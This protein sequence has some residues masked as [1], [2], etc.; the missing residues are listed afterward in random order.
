MSYG[1]VALVT[2]IS[3]DVVSALSAAGYPALTDGA[4]LL[5][6]QHQFEQSAPP[7]II[8]TPVASKFGPR[9]SS[10]LSALTPAPPGGTSPGVGLLSLTM[11]NYGGN[12][13]SPT[14]SFT[15]GGG[16][17]AAATATV[18]G[19]SIAKITLTNS[20][21]GYTSAP[22]VVITDADGTG[23]TAVANLQ[24]YSELLAEAQQRSIYT[25]SVTFE[26]RCWGM[27]PTTDD[28]NGDYDYTQVLYQQMIRSCRNLAVGS[29]R[30][31]PNGNWTDGS[32]TESQLFRN[33]REFVFRIEI[34][35]PILDVLLQYA[36]TGT[37]GE[38]AITSGNDTVTVE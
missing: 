38:I 10:S 3:A 34:D 28:P 7:R 11:T 35:V 17:G 19:S 20:G 23:A 1:I 36:P 18:V 33:G 5:G 26:V 27:V 30:F 21:S 12:Y 2:A 22:T 31:Q 37:D 14:V 4:I 16:T 6:R 15:G 29:F 13:V 9:A 25:E 8:M 32:I 24:P